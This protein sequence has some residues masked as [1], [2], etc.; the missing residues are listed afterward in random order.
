[1]L[2]RPELFPPGIEGL[3]ELTEK[4]D[5]YMFGLLLLMVL[6]G[7]RT[8]YS[9]GYPYLLPFT[10]QEAIETNTLQLVIDMNMLEIAQNFMD[11]F[12]EVSFRCCS[13]EQVHRPSIS[14]FVEGLTR[15]QALQP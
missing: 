12:L 6:C 14:T 8:D 9:G 11:M 2:I 1:M 15:A 4:S 5:V 7:R 10:V 3:T 13:H